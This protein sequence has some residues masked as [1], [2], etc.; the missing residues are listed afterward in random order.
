MQKVPATRRQMWAYSAIAGSLA[1]LVSGLFSL[2]FPRAWGIAVW[3][4]T[5]I[6]LTTLA[7]RSAT[8]FFE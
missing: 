6:I 3:I 4:V 7:G 1:V 8:L 2:L 5:A